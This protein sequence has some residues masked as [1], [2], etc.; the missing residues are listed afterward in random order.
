MLDRR[1]GRP[2][3]RLT[4]RRSAVG[5][6]VVQGLGPLD[7]GRRRLGGSRAARN[8]SATAVAVG[9]KSGRVAWSRSGTAVAVGRRSRP[10][11]RSRSAMAVAVGRR[12]SRT[13][14]RLRRACL[15][16]AN[17]A[18]DRQSRRIEGSTPGGGRWQRAGLRPATAA[19]GRR[20]GGSRTRAGLRPAGVIVG[21]SGA[22]GGLRSGGRGL[23]RLLGPGGTRNPPVGR[24]LGYRR[25]HRPAQLIVTVGGVGA[26]GSGWQWAGQFEVTV[27]LDRRPRRA[28][29]GLR[30]RTAPPLRLRGLPLVH[31]LPTVG[32]PFLDSTRFSA[33]RR[34]EPRRRRPAPR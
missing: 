33:D 9:R 10:A 29:R 11:A 12:R 30:S 27:T 5:V 28:R 26:G 23:V 24:G 16:P 6:G 2:G 21:G 17:A 32:G 4:V 19:V 34:C 8:R 14:G 15:R 20:T 22:R 1:R 31:A 3:A 13:S 18:V 7:D 25:A